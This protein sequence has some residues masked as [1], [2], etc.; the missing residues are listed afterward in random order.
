MLI[1]RLPALVAAGTIGLLGSVSPG[2]GQPT[3]SPSPCGFFVPP[4]ERATCGMLN[5][6][7]PADPSA[8]RLF[9][10]ILHSVGDNPA[11]DPVIW[12]MG[13]PGDPAFQD[14]SAEDW[15]PLTAA[16]RRQRD[17]IVFDAR[18]VG[19]SEPSLDCPDPTP[20]DRAIN[21]L[22]ADPLAAEVVRLRACGESLIA[23]GID[24][25]EFRLPNHAADV[26]RIART[27]GHA[28]VNLVAL[29]YGTRVALQVIREAPDL[30]RAAV[31][32]GPYPSNVNALVE[33][34][35]VRAGV[36]DLLFS[37][38]QIDWRCRAAIG[39]LRQHFEAMIAWLVEGNAVVTRW[40]GSDGPVDVLV[41]PGDVID[42]LILM[43][44]DSN[45]LPLM[46]RAIRSGGAGDLRRMIPFL[47]GGPGAGSV[48]NEG[49]TLSA[50]CSEDWAYADATGYARN[51]AANT[52]FSS[53]HAVSIAW[54]VCRDWP[55]VAVEPRLR[56][57]VAADT[58]ILALVGS[59]DPITPPSWAYSL[60]RTLPNLEIL[61]MAS[62]SHGL[63]GRFA[64]VTT[65]AA[66]F[67]DMPDQ[68]T[69]GLCRD[70][71]RPPRFALE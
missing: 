31:L 20:A 65:A 71:T 33:A 54:A 21:T 11:P 24:F 28:E 9:L 8:P 30:V 48:D 56:A 59:Y 60:A 41:T 19:R 53:G 5:T 58:P 14:D 63:L 57:P 22:E 49:V 27:F 13:G 6:A 3:F 40:A 39:D 61:E 50:E 32:D 4:G 18:G 43:A 51:V 42:A 45:T 1:Q 26:V 46:P 47:T 16:F 17:V 68:P 23:Q 62:G 36:F 44:G 66:A 7:G 25:S 55:V 38:C 29:S 67:L 52:P 34:P 37:D 2:L 70:R 10:A 64:C 12:L 69:A 15:W 35:V